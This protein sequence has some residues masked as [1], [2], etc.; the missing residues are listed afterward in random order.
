MTKK[1]HFERTNISY[2]DV[3][4]IKRKKKLSLGVVLKQANVFSNFALIEL[5]FPNSWGEKR[6]LNYIGNQLPKRKLIR[7]LTGSG[8]IVK[9]YRLNQP[10]SW[11]GLDWLDGGTITYVR[12]Q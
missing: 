1:I 5:E 7:I 11:G 6:V 2:D 9:K 4:V 12:G 10:K 3:S 8:I